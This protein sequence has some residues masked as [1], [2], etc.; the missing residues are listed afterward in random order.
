[1]TD[2]TNKDLAEALR[3]IEGLPLGAA[4]IV[5]LA[6]DRLDPPVAV[7]EECSDPDGWIE[8]SGDRFGPD[9]PEGAKIEVQMKNGSTSVSE[10]HWWRFGLGVDSWDRK[11]GEDCIASYRVVK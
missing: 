7:A 1:M 3:A 8:W 6:A 4:L 5:R 11:H 9:V 2:P 10:A